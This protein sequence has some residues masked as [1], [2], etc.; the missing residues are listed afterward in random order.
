[1]HE[2]HEEMIRGD[3]IFRR[4]V[5]DFEST[6]ECDQGSISEAL[7]LESTAGMTNLSSAS[8]QMRVLNNLSMFVTIV[9]HTNVSHR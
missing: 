8:M 4:A 1:M 5:L 9:V 7:A 2:E 6:H 3:A